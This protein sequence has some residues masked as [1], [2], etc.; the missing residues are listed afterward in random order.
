MA[1]AVVATLARAPRLVERGR[2]VGSDIGF[3]LTRRLAFGTQVPQEYVDF[4][5]EML[6]ATP[7]DV[8]AE[9]FPGFDS[10]DKYAALA[11]LW[12]GADGGRSAAAATRSR[13]SSTASRLARADRPALSWS[14]SLEPGHM[15]MLECPRRGH[16]GNRAAL[17]RAAAMTD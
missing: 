13:P 10:H 8:V 1:P 3:V 6:A 2:R 12:I 5:D 14:R 4:T 7:F 16:E 11:A 9:F 17:V 15:V